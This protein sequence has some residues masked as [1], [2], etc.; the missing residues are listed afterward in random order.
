MKLALI[1]AAAANNV[2]GYENRLPWHLPEDLKYFKSTTMGKPL[3]MGRKTYDSIGKPLPGRINI[4]VTRQQDWP[5]PAGVLVAHDLDAAIALAEVA[6]SGGSGGA[7]EIMVIGGAEIFG[8]S[9]KRAQKVYLTRIEKDFLGD[10]YFP[11]LS[12]QEW[13]KVSTIA[14]SPHSSEPYSL[15]V[16]ERIDQ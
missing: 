4:V 9:I 16:Y 11:E 8:A 5:A 12:P 6:L 7:D 1:V 15:Q 13:L 3:I 14:G 10:T 2:I